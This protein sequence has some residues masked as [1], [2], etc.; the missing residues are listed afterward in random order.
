ML[1]HSERKTACQ[2]VYIVNLDTVK[3]HDVI[4]PHNI[5]FCA[6]MPTGSMCLDFLQI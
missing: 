5:V 2:L 4:E 3:R 6:A 1:A